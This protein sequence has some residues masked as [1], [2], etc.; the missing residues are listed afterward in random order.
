LK[1]E[2]LTKRKIF[3]RKMGLEIA[4]KYCLMKIGFIQKFNY[5]VKI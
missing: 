5:L 4:L 1:K 3:K 2:E